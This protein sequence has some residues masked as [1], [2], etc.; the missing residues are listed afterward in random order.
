MRAGILGS[1]GSTPVRSTRHGKVGQFH[2]TAPPTGRDDD[3]AHPVPRWRNRHKPGMIV[4]VWADTLIIV[5]AIL[6][7]ITLAELLIRAVFYLARGVT[8]PV[9]VQCRPTPGAVPLQLRDGGPDEITYR[10]HPELRLRA[11]RPAARRRSV[12]SRSW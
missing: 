12:N 9:Q 6:G 11:Q 4:H 10:L 2:R 3:Q 5:V 8:R 7:I 1:A